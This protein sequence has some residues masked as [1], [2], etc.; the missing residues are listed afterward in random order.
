MI[1]ILRVEISKTNLSF[2]Y[3]VENKFPYEIWICDD[4]NIYGSSNPVTKVEK[5]AIL[6][7]KRLRLPINVLLEEEVVARYFRLASGKTHT[8]RIT[9]ELPIDNYS[10]L[11][12]EDDNSGKTV[13]G[14]C[15]HAILE[16][17]YFSENLQSKLSDRIRRGETND[18]VLIGHLWEEL[19]K[20]KTLKAYIDE[21]MSCYISG[22]F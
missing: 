5:D 11:F 4:F 1:K 19:E 9:M 8:G 13:I 12:S 10:P 2:D 14:E 18:Q 20:E 21:K 16:I 22:S 3:I 7:S 15:N 17:G 6:V